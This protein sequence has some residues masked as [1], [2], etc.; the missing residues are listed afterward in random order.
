MKKIKAPRIY[1]LLM[2][3]GCL[4]EN[5]RLWPFEG[6]NMFETILWPFR[7]ILF[8][9]YHKIRWILMW[10]PHCHLIIHDLQ[11]SP[12]IQYCW[13]LGLECG[14]TACFLK[15]FNTHKLRSYFN[16]K[17]VMGLVVSNN[18]TQFCIGFSEVWCLNTNFSVHANYENRR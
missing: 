13:D 11:K 12:H 9:S 18:D 5:L 8:L 14:I 3:K 6:H 7:A 16:V 15:V 17:C 4:P 1:S 10:L 2:A